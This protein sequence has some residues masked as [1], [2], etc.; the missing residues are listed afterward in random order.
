MH[1][2]F[3]YNKKN[4]KLKRKISQVIIVNFYVSVTISQSCTFNTKKISTF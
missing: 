4:K 2:N 1:V 3:E